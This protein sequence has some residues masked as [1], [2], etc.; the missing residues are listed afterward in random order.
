MN[1]RVLEKENIALVPKGRLKGQAL[2]QFPLVTVLAPGPTVQLNNILQT[3][4]AEDVA[5]GMEEG[6]T[7]FHRLIHSTNT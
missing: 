4:G 1:Q 5:V 6:R 7:S 3:V 2:N